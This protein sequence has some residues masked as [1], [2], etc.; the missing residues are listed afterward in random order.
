VTHPFRRPT[1]EHRALART[2]RLR[3]WCVAVLIAAIGAASTFDTQAPD[4]VGGDDGGA[5]SAPRRVAPCLSAFVAAH[6]PDVSA[7]LRVVPFFGA[8]LAPLPARP[9]SNRLELPVRF[10][11]VGALA[12]PPLPSRAPPAA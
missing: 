5:L 11:R 10:A 3:A 9:A 7:A 2:R 12:C 8:A 6:R 4:F 1:P